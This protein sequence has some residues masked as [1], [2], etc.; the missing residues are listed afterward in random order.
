M[1]R[2]LRAWAINRGGKNSV[3]NL[4]YGPRTR[5]VIIRGIYKSNRPQVSMGFSKFS[6]R[7]LPPIF[8]S[9]ILQS[10]R[11]ENLSHYFPY[12]VKLGLLVHSRSFL[13]NQKARNAIVGA[14]NLLNADIPRCIFNYFF[15]R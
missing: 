11:K 13:A 2:A 4:R 9:T 5:L 8:I 7:V 10:V 1:A 3:R 12:D 6:N 14:E 15:Y